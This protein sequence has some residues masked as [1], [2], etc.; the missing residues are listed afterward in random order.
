M[1][2]GHEATG[3]VVEVGA[4]VQGFAPGHRVVF[5]FVPMC[6]HCDSCASG[7]PALC[8][9]GA[10]ANGA[11]TLLA[12]TRHWNDG[13]NSELQH[14]L[15][16]SGFAEYTPAVSLVA[17]ERTVKGSYM[18]SAVPRRDIPRYSAM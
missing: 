1:V 12:G 17:E 9:P 7:R 13:G 5:S 2:L 4:H 3:E 15:G 6:G 16:V 11:G 14:H 8:E 10:L 18:G